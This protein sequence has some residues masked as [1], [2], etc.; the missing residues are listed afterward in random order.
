MKID[1]VVGGIDP[2]SSEVIDQA[3]CLL[4]WSF[5]TLAARVAGVYDCLISFF[6]LRI[7]S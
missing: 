3:E 2:E 1:V 7:S 6:F 5:D 4:A